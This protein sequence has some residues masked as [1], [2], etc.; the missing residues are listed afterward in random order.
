MRLDQVRQQIVAEL[1]DSISMTGATTG[2]GVGDIPGPS[3]PAAV[4]ESMTHVA[5]HA[6]RY[7]GEA[8]VEAFLRD[9]NGHSLAILRE[10]L[11]RPLGENVEAVRGLL[12]SV[13]VGDTRGMGEIAVIAIVA[14]YQARMLSDVG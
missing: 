5:G 4:V 13:K 11:R 7:I 6:L 3:S 12:A 9:L 14:A 8:N 10:A 2:D 1:A